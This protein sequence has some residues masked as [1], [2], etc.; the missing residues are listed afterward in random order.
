MSARRWLWSLVA[1][2][3]A[4]SL[5]CG[6]YTGPT[7][8][9]KQQKVAPTAPAGAVFG[10]YILIS[11]VWTCVEECEDQDDNTDDPGGRQK[12]D[13]LPGGTLDSLP[14]ATVPDF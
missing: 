2:V 10:R 6:D 13:G 3:A 8:P 4:A 9:V 14:T 12:I 5:A 7:S 1:L 11:G